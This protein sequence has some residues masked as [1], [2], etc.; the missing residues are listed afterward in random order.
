MSNVEQIQAIERNIKEAKKT[1]DLGT[2]LERLKLNKDF[3]VLVLAGY[4]E[5]EAIRLVQAKAAPDMQTAE[6]QESIVKQIDAIGS[7]FMFFQ[8]VRM[9]A[10][11]AANSISAD[12]EMLV[13]MQNGD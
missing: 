1:L 11:M 10:G 13:E 8:A 2:A 4:F 5:T 6:K 12:E 7:L 3:R 9:K